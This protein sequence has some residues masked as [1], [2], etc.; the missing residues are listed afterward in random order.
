MDQEPMP[1]F[2]VKTGQCCQSGFRED[3]H[4]VEPASAVVK[5]LPLNDPL[6]KRKRRIKRS[7]LA[8]QSLN[9]FVS[10]NE[11]RS[12]IRAIWNGCY[13]ESTEDV[14]VPIRPYAMAID[15]YDSTEDRCLATCLRDK[16]CYAVVY[17]MVGGR[18]VFTCEFYEQID[19]KNA[20]TYAPFVNIYMK[21]ATCALSL[22]SSE[23]ERS[24]ELEQVP[25]KSDTDAPAGTIEESSAVPPIV[26]KKRWFLKKGI[27]DHVKLGF[28]D[29]FGE[30]ETQ[31]SWDCVWRLVFKV[32]TLVYTS[33]KNYVI[34]GYHTKLFL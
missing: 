26:T 18:K 28:E 10:W 13:M 22:M 9:P 12:R 33:F 5:R 11:V 2:M 8:G 32:F 24:M 30:V 21:R 20:P 15:G 6:I 34:W 14:E 7:E 3:I 17:G 29:I 23:P 19:A 31:H 1:E 16:R 25:L 27:N 4:L